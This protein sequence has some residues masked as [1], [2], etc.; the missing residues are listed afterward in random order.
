V[1]LRFW[2]PLQISSFTYLFTYLLIYLDRPR[3]DWA[4]RWPAGRY[5]SSVSGLRRYERDSAARTRCNL[6]CEYSGTRHRSVNSVV[7]LRDNQ[8]YVLPRTHSGLLWTTGAVRTPKRLI[9]DWSVFAA[10]RIFADCAPPPP[11]PPSSS[12]R[13]GL[14]PVGV[15]VWRFFIYLFHFDSVLYWVTELFALAG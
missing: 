6:S 4:V 15:W 2:R 12:L 13:S 1:F 5:F 14:M 9:K 11:P 10:T 8:S 7:L 3:L